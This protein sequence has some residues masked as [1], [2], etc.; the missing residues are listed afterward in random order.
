MTR[1]P[2]GDS[3]LGAKPA[4]TVVPENA[5]SAKKSPKNDWLLKELKA[6]L[7]AKKRDGGQQGKKTTKDA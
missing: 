5:K 3:V 2:N 6:R 4:Y 7:S 1:G